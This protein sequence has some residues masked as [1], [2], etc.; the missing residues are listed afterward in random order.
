MTKIERFVGSEM[1]T[2]IISNEERNHIIEMVKSLDKSGLF[3]KGVC[4]TI[5]RCVKSWRGNT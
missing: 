5:G 1:K 2:L 3:I 4:D